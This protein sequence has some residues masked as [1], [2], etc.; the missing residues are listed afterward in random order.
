[1]LA[2][3]CFWTW[4]LETLKLEFTFT[5]CT[6]FHF[7]QALQ[8]LGGPRTCRQTGNQAPIDLESP[9][10]SGGV[11]AVNPLQLHYTM[12]SSAERKQQEE[13][14]KIAPTSSPLPASTI[15]C[16]WWPFRRRQPDPEPAMTSVSTQNPWTLVQGFAWT[17]LSVNR[18]S[19]IPEREEN[20]SHILIFPSK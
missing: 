16:I 5:H 1:M 3:S 14:K 12:I 2:V 4:I 6:G 18:D 10:A 19:N 20:Q 9:F 15:T 13:G 17:G 11:E 8:T 7:L